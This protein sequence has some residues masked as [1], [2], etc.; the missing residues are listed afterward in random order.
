MKELVAKLIRR[1]G[2]EALTR[3]TVS[4]DKVG[5]L[6]YHDPSVAR[7]EAHL[8]FLSTR[9]AFVS[10]DDLSAALSTRDWSRIPRNA[11]VVTFDDGHRGNRELLPVF[12]RF[13]LH[14]TIYLCSG[15][16]RGDGLFWFRLPGVDP[17]P[18]KLMSPAERATF[19][20]N[21]GISSAVD[22]HALTPAEVAE[23]APTVD[24]GSHTISH[25]VLPLCTDNVAAHEI[26]QSRAEIEGISGTPCRHLSYPNGDYTDRETR[27]VREAG[28]ASAR[29][30]EIGWNGRDADPLRLRIISL[31]DFASVDVLAAHLAGLLAVRR[32]VP[33]L[34]HRRALQRRVPR[35]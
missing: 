30:T 13:G 8:E 25:P 32:L 16:V 6:V 22:R 18:L 7:F 34:L 27:L 21:A 3:R 33:T 26:A 29:T 15:I 35:T 4:R 5:I 28:Y 17:E 9:Y 12:E 1:C 31:A 23:L 20:E 11:L 10:L 24:F 19:L 14:P 2:L